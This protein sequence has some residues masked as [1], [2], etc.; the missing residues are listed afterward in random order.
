MTLRPCPI[1]SG[2]AFFFLR[3]FLPK[4]RQFL[5]AGA[6]TAFQTIDFA[7]LFPARGLLG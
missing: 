5:P 2:G 3:P 4:G 7:P 1:P 6:G